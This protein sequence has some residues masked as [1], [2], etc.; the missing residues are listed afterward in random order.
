MGL[1]KN[2]KRTTWRVVGAAPGIARA[3]S[4]RASGAIHRGGISRMPRLCTTKARPDASRA[5]CETVP[6]YLFVQGGS[7]RARRQRRRGSTHGATEAAAVSDAWG[8]TPG[9][10]RGARSNKSGLALPRPTST[11]PLRPCTEVQPLV[12]RFILDL[13]SSHNHRRR[14]RYRHHAASYYVGRGQAT[15]HIS[16]H[17]RGR[18]R[19][20]MLDGR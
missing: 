1:L 14:R 3:S 2:P 8:L 6:L 11:A 9:N 4:R 17:V 5:S 19:R 16:S 12:N 13:S 15:T 7:E 10:V 20:R 18:A